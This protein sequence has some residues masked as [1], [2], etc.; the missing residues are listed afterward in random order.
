MN[1]KFKNQILL[2]LVVSVCLIAFIL[3]ILGVFNFIEMKLL[4]WRMSA[5]AV[6]EINTD[7]IRLYSDSSTRNELE[8]FNTYT[9]SEK[10]LSRAEI[11]KLIQYVEKANPR[12]ILLNIDLKNYEDTAVSS[13]SPDTKLSETLAENKNII[14]STILKKDE[15]G[16]N[17]FENSKIFPAKKSLDAI[18]KNKSLEKNFTYYAHSQIPPMFVNNAIV[19]V[20]NL[21]N[22]KET[23]RSLKPLYK[24][25]HHSKNYIIPSVSFAAFLKLYGLEKQQLVVEKNKLFVADKVFNLNNDGEILL[26]LKKK[27]LYYQA[28]PIEAILKGIHD[29]TNK[30]ALDEKTFENDIFKGKIVIIEEKPTNVSIKTLPNNDKYTAGEITALAIDNYLSNEKLASYTPKFIDIFL[31]T[32]LCLIIAFSN[33]RFNGRFFSLTLI[34]IYLAA[35]FLAFISHFKIVVPIATPLFFIL[36]SYFI[37]Y[38]VATMLKKQKRGIVI[39]AFKNHVSKEILNKLI[40]NSDKLSLKPSKKFITTM[41]CNINGFTEL[42]N[43]IPSELLIERLNEILNVIISRSLKNNGTINKINNNSLIVYWGA[44]ISNNNENNS[45]AKDAVKTAIEVWQKISQINEK[46]QQNG[47]FIMDLN[48]VVHSGEALVGNI[49]NSNLTSYSAFGETI[50]TVYK[51]EKICVQFGKNILVSETTYN[52]LKTCKNQQITENSIEFDYAGAISNKTPPV[53]K[54][55]LYEVREIKEGEND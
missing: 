9:K 41:Y 54:L 3:K 52:L 24:I 6:S 40:K 30:F 4:D 37:S 12:L 47:Q 39:S 26:N 45:D 11:A 34:L 53:K 42:T 2:L 38:F 18:I 55:S 10:G 7:I 35:A 22:S 14:I 48:I 33:L 21:P 28:Y 25:T 23:T 16:E 43:S 20:A 1:E 49:G 27:G 29:G 5:S 50:D 13:I 36:S 31:T 17:E 51:I 46:Y 15:N 19:G 44:P 8:N 32:V